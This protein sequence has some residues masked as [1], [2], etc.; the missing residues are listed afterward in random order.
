M[1]IG[2]LSD[3]HKLLRPEVVRHLHG[4]EAILHAGDI[5]SRQLLQELETIA[6]VYAVRGNADREWAEGLPL[7]LEVKLDGLSIYMTHRKKDLPADLSAYDLAVVGHSPKYEETVCV[8]PAGRKT[9]VFNPGSCGP[10]RFHLPLTLAILKTEPT[11]W[12]I[13]RIDIER[14]VLRPRVDPG[15]IRAQAEIVGKELKKGHGPQWIAE[16]Y[17]MDPSVAEQIAR[18]YVTHPG[19]SADEILVKLGL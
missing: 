11:G 7:F 10:G 18:L 6:P 2:I 16:K 19:V 8:S 14:P 15:D 5:G 3:T 9:T 12:K 13:R 4:C 17:G 1:I